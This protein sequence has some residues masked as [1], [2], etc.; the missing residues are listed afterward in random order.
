MA[1]AFV[2]QVGNV[3]EITGTG[4]YTFSAGVSVTAGNTLLA[5]ISSDGNAASEITAVSDNKGNTWTKDVETVNTLQSTER[6]ISLWRAPI[7][8]GGSGLIITITYNGA[9]SNN[10]AIVVQEVSSAS[11]LTLDKT[12]GGGA[13]TATTAPTTATTAATTNANEIVI[14]AFVSNSTQ[15]S[16]AA[17]TGYSNAGSNITSNANVGME[18]KLV[19]ATGTQVATATLGTSRAYGALI[20]TYYEAGGGGGGGPSTGLFFAAL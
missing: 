12:A 14:A 1:I 18:S 15:T 16:F 4:S 17:G 11:A 5:S 3:G 13:T 19:S 7:T 9:N 6:Y 8:T 10:S 20:A 2:Q